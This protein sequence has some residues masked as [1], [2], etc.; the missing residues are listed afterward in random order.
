MPRL[1]MQRLLVGAATLAVSSCSCIARGTRIRTPRGERMIEELT[2]GDSV[3]CVALSTGALVAANLLATRMATRECIALGF[4]EGQLIA[5]SDH[6]LYCPMTRE[7]APAGDWALGQRTHL[8]RVTREG[9]APIAVERSSIFAGVRDVFDLSVDHPFH[10]FVANG[11]LVHNKKY[12]RV[13]TAETVTLRAETTCGAAADLILTSTTHC[14]L[15]VAGGASSGLPSSGHTGSP[16]LRGFSLTDF[17]DDGGVT[18]NC[19]ATPAGGTVLDIACTSGCS[20]TLTP[21]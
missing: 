11:V 10:N 20:G 16:I 12:S 2:V 19:N 15:V 17:G 3:V 5:T 21:K 7:W 9:V 6:P 4:G 13:C 18:L 1:R 14:A 8:L